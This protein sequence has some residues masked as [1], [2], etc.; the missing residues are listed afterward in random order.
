MDEDP[1]PEQVDPVRGEPRWPMAVA[2][3]AASA[4]TT[5]RPAELR[6]L[7]AWVLPIVE[8]LLL[9]VLVVRDPGRI[10]RRSRNLRYVS[11]CVV[12]LLLV[13]ALVATG[14][15]ITVLVRG[16]HAT[17]SAESLL[18]AGAVVWVSNIVAFS[19]LYWEL[20]SGGAAARA[21]GSTAT[22]DL[23]FTQQLSPE[24][25]P[26]GWRP[27]FHDYLYLGLT[28]STAFSPTDV[29]PLAGWAKLAMAVQ[30]LISLSV[31]GL[32][33]ARAVNV[34]A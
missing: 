31:L 5:L 21:H 17:D 20:D 34:L 28:S 13:D 16:G 10:D 25:A 18:L 22:P 1:A 6:L 15:L 32:V 26:A 27:Q 7:P 24:L 14:H 12:A 4:L 2:V 3:V 19:L 8:V 33:I 30:S 11:I 9:V 23:A 29:M